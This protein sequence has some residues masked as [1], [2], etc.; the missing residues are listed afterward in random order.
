MLLVKSLHFT[1]DVT[2]SLY[3]AIMSGAQVH[4]TS[5]LELPKRLIDLT[6]TAYDSYN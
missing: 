5:I 4:P 1:F 6:Y 3:N 2:P